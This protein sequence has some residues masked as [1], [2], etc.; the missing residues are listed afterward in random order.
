MRIKPGK[1]STRDYI[2]GGV[3][4]SP[5]DQEE[6]RRKQYADQ[7][8]SNIEGSMKSLGTVEDPDLSGGWGA[9]EHE[10]WPYSDEED[11]TPGRRS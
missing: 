11:L 6:D 8:R 10:N 7:A 5:A 3:V 1:A 9:H 4:K 2:K